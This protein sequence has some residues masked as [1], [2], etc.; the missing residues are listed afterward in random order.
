MRSTQ[1]LK[2][3]IYL[4]NVEQQG[5]AVSGDETIKQFVKNWFGDVD[6]VAGGYE[7]NIEYFYSYNEQLKGIADMI[8]MSD[9]D[10]IYLYMIEE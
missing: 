9:T 6:I 5:I 4:N 1:I 7:N 3:V 10:T 2:Q 8:L